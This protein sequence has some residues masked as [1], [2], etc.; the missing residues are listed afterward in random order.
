[1]EKRKGLLTEEHPDTLEVMAALSNLYREMG[2]IS[3]AV[4]M[5]EE[6]ATIKTRIEKKN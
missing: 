6:V 5:T 2:K 4:A 1:M 3:E